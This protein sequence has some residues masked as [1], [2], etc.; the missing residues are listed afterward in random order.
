V[1]LLALHVARQAP[2][3][4]VLCFMWLVVG[5]Y[6]FVVVVNGSQLVTRWG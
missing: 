1:A 2:R 4:I 3:L 5:V 6:L